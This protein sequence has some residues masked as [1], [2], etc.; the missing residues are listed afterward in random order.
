MI[1]NNKREMRHTSDKTTSNVMYYER[2]DL[3]TKVIV[4]V[5]F[6][7]D[8]KMRRMTF[9]NCRVFMSIVVLHRRI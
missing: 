7:S 1:E 4:S 6:Y 2:S 5:E 8:R 9:P 3:I